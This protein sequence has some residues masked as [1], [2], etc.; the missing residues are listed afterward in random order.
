MPKDLNIAMTCMSS[1][2]KIRKRRLEPSWENISSY[3]DFDFDAV[4]L[5]NAMEDSWEEVVK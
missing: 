4:Y 1:W 5:K 3:R 2:T